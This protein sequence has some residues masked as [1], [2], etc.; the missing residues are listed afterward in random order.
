MYRKIYCNRFL[1]WSLHT[2]SQNIAPRHAD[3]VFNVRSFIGS[4]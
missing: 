4:I 1:W 3:D 2:Y